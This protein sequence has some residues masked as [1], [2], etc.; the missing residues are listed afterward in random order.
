ML[1]KFIVAYIDL[2]ISVSSIYIN[3]DICCI[4]VKYINNHIHTNMCA[5]T[6]VHTNITRLKI[7]F[8]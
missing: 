6:H 1:L 7:L 8:L 3:F 5:H 4:L 2:S